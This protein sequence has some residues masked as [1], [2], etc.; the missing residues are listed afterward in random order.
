MASS[1]SLNS[2]FPNALSHTAFVGGFR[3]VKFD[4]WNNERGDG[5]CIDAGNARTL[6]R[7]RR[8]VPSTARDCHGPFDKE[9][10]IVLRSG[11][12]K[13]I[14]LR[15]RLEHRD[16]IHRTMRIGGEIYSN[17]SGDLE[18][19]PRSLHRASSWSGCRGLWRLS[20]SLLGSRLLV[21]TA[22]MLN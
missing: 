17:A 12:W 19:L 1:Q 2:N 15:M 22:R 9:E 3:A 16:Q 7:T 4:G 6:L 11:D 8:S 5:S 10:G 13:S 14:S 18:V 20:G 21:I